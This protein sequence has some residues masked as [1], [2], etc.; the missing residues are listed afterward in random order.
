MPKRVKKSRKDMTAVDVAKEHDIKFREGTTDENVILEVINSRCYRRASIGFD[1]EDGESWLDL[2]GNIGAFA[3]YCEINGATAESY[4]PDSECYELLSQNN[5]QGETFNTAVSG[6]KAKKLQFFSS[7]IEGNKYRGTILEQ[8]R[9]MKENGEVDNLY[10][11]KFKKRKFDGVK[12]DIEGAEFDILDEWLLPRCNKLCFEYHTSRD[13]S[14]KN[15]KRRVKILRERFHVVNYTPELD[16]IMA[17]GGNQ[18][19]F[20]DRV[21]WCMDPKS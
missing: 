17:L 12:M 1:V 10:A 21:I 16:K 15:L 6:K 2:G 14:M 13:Q 7:S 4:E 3:V 11:G 9:M 5:T 8:K 19:S 18:K 20:H